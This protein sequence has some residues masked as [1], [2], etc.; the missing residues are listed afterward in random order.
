HG[1][2]PP[3]PHL[4]VA[5]SDCGPCHP[6][7][8]ARP[9]DP[10]THINGVVDLTSGDGACGACHGG[11]PDDAGHERHAG[12]TT[13]AYGATTREPSPDPSVSYAL[14]CG[15]CHPHDATQH[16]DGH[17]DLPSTC[18]DNYCHSAGTA[19][20]TE[21]I[22]SHTAPTWGEDTL[23]CDGCHGAPPDYAQDDPKSNSHSDHRFGCEFC[24]AGTTHDGATIADAQLHAN[25][26]YD[27]APGPYTWRDVPLAFSY[28]FDPGGGTCSDISCHASIG[29]STEIRWGRI[30]L[31]A[32]LQVTYLPGCFEV[33]YTVSHE[34]GGTAP[35][36]YH[37]DFGDGTGAAGVAVSHAYADGTE[38][39]VTLELRDANR[40]LG[41]IRAQVAPR[42]LAN[43]PA[44]PA[45]MI[46]AFG[47]DVSLTDLSTDADAQLCTH[48]GDGLVRVRWGYSVPNC[49]EW[50]CSGTI[51]MESSAQVTLGESPTGVTFAHTYPQTN[52]VRTYALRHL[53]TDNSGALVGAP[54]VSLTL[55]TRRNLTLA[56]RIVDG[57]TVGMAGVAVHLVSQPAGFLDAWVTSDADGRYE[58]SAELA[59]VCYDA[60]PSSAGYGF[61]PSSTR[62]CSAPTSERIA[63]DDLTATP[64]VPEE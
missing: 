3:P 32:I 24:H 46:S 14:G 6:F 30:Y 64:V 26:S 35:Y 9:K 5:S 57:A 7:V 28:Q 33:A 51:T 8:A 63:L 23:A 31:N 48:S 47:Y 22:E 36:S 29:R 43:T 19:V 18:A 49:D 4:A 54:D 39:T 53:V 40:H 21:V 16:L 17:R 15:L 55:P 61:A 52:S 20:A 38:R 10:S 50:D 25:G 12:A 59:D 42:P 11:P 13:P 34:V 37:W 45:S 1:L 62:A 56:G 41:L 60:T 44:V 2:P 27:L 58:Y